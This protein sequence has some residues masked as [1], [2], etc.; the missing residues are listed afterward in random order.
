VKRPVHVAAAAKPATRVTKSVSKTIASDTVA[1]AAS[2][3]ASAA[4]ATTA[5]TSQ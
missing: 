4:P 5:Q 1:P 2:Q 3:I